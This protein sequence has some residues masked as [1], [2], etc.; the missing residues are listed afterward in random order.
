MVSWNYQTSLV[1][2]LLQR[3]SVLWP[4]LMCCVGVQLMVPGTPLQLQ[5]QEQQR[6]GV[7]SLVFGTMLTEHAGCSILKPL[8]ANVAGLVLKHWTLECCMVVN[9]QSQCQ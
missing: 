5:P 7:T 3:C 2:L 8:G 1:F 4:I 6:H 9:Q